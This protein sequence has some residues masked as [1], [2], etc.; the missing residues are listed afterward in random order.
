MPEVRCPETS[1]PANEAGVCTSPSITLTPS[2]ICSEFW[3]RFKSEM[4][5]RNRRLIEEAR[6]Q[7][8]LTEEG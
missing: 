7:A 3:D 5:A 8:T 6:G 1:C 2:G 4:A